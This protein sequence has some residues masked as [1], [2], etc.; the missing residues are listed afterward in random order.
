MTVITFG[1]K[2]ADKV[3]AGR[4]TVTFRKWPKARVGVGEICD[5]ARMGYP[6]RKFA[7]VKV[8]GLRRVKL[9][10][11]DEKLAKRDGAESPTEVKA[12]WSKQG[13]GAEDELWLVEFELV[14]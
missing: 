2:S 12:Y 6:P 5:A 11:I 9:R 1:G 7:R 14:K 3:L 4:K 8:S 13:F 10:E